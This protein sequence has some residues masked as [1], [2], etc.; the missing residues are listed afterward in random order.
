VVTGLQDLHTSLQNF[1]LKTFDLARAS[2]DVLKGLYGTAE[3]TTLYWA[4][5]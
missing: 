1:S 2:E 3:D 5:Q 4:H